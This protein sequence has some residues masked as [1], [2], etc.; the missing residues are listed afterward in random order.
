VVAYPGG[1]LGGV[2]RALRRIAGPEFNPYTIQIE[3][4]DW[5]AELFDALA[6]INT[7]LIDF[8]RDLWGYISLG[9]F[10][11]RLKAG[12][13]GSSTMPHK[14]NPID[15]EN[16]EGN[17]GIANAL[18]AT[19]PRSCRS[20]AGSATSP[21]PPCC[22][23]GRRASATCAAR[24]RFAACA[25]SASS[26]PTRSAWPPTSTLPGKCSPSRCRR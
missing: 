16:A 6:R 9:Y 22:A 10:K 19:S 24:A 1:R 13:V 8:C 3:P 17:L 26:R 4:H 12:E 20:A 7:I 11:Q 21:T 25:A 5:I 14:V 23:T 18:L 15:F 2:R